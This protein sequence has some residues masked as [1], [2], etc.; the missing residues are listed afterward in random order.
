MPEMTGNGPQSQAEPGA[1]EPWL[2]SHWPFLNLRTILLAG[3][4]SLS[5]NM[6]G[7]DCC[8][9]FTDYKKTLKLRKW[10]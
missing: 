6:C 2:T 3:S 1:A 10:R 5:S 4:L 7:R 8:D 9:H